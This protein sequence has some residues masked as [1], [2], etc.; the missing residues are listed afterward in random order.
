M[1]TN[2]SLTWQSAVIFIIVWLVKSAG[3]EITEGEI[4][5]TIMTLIQV[6]SAVGILYGRWRQGDLKNIFGKKIPRT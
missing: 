5:T 3:L 4:T 6:F 2:L 1:F